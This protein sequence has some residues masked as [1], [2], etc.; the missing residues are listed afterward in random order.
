MAHERIDLG[1]A[2]ALIS[3][4]D[5]RLQE[6]QHAV[7]GARLVFPML[8][9]TSVLSSLP[10]HG[11]VV[12]LIARIERA[13]ASALAT[14]RSTS[15]DLQLGTLDAHGMDVAAWSPDGQD[16]RDA[17][18]DPVMVKL[19]EINGVG[20]IRRTPSGVATRWRWRGRP[21]NPDETSP[22]VRLTGLPDAF[23]PFVIRPTTKTSSR[24]TAV[25]FGEGRGH[26][27]YV[28]E[29]ETFRLELS[30]ELPETMATAL[31]GGPLRRLV[32]HPA[33]EGWT[34]GKPFENDMGVDLLPPD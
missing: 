22:Y 5:R 6:P 15:L 27:V 20:R 30:E 31:G 2:A 3:C 7:Q 12:G 25:R 10:G 16:P 11:K 32:D 33:L 8:Q 18:I 19:M 13:R 1:L 21:S 4:L 26:A 34:I 29:H 24:R 9:A 17:C 14:G 23:P 28:H